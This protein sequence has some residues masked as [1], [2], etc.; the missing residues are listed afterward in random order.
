MPVITEQ[1]LNDAS[2][3]AVSFQLF[4]SGDENTD[5]HTRLGR[6][7]PTLAKLAKFVRDQPIEALVGQSYA[8][9]AS[10]QAAIVAGQIAENAV[11]NVYSADDDLLYLL[12]KNVGG[13][14]TPLLDSQGQHKAYPSFAYISKQL[15]RLDSNV[16]NNLPNAGIFNVAGKNAFEVIS[17]I[18]Q[19]AF[20]LDMRGVA[21][22][23]SGEF[24]L[25]EIMMLP[26]PPES[27]Y[28][29]AIGDKAGR[30]V[31]GVGKKGW[32]EILYHRMEMVDGQDAIIITDK[33]NATSVGIAANGVGFAYGQTDKETDPILQFVERLHILIYG[34]SLSI[35]AQGVP[36]LGT[37]TQDALM[38]NT[39]VISRFSTP[40]SFVDLVER[41]QETIA[42]A[43]A[44]D[45]VK[46]S[47]GMLGRKLIL[48]SGGV[49]GERIQNLIKGTTPYN[50][51]V[52][53]AIWAHNQ[54]AT[55]G[56]QHSPDLVCWLQGE[57]NMADGM[58]K[59]VYKNYLATLRSDLETSLASIRGG[60][61]RPFTM[62]TYQ[63]SSHGYYNGTPENPP[64]LIALGQLELALTDPNIQMIGPTYYGPRA[65]VSG[66][67]HHN[68]HGYRWVGLFFQKAIRY[69]L[70]TGEKWKPVHP[71]GARKINDTTV[72]I[73]FH[74]PVPPLVFDTS[75]ITQ[76]EDGQNGIEVHDSTG[77]LTVLSTTIVGGTQVKVVTQQ[78]IGSGAFIATA[79]TPENRGP[80]DTENNRYPEWFFGP[81]TG[82][83]TTLHDSDP[84]T[85]DLGNFDN[86]PYPL[87]N[88]C[89]ISKVEVTS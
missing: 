57:A 70:R 53:Q 88:Y 39:G 23:Q 33:E 75:Y 2:L 12:Y 69:W 45:F 50:Q 30:V 36:L 56:Y 16:I 86:K 40:T 38:Y 63:T 89:V 28:C 1:Q 68:S 8:D 82:V 37:P 34:Q 49:S 31:F 21:N 72:I 79:W 60:A 35:G 59:D 13:T 47:G 9:L 44:H 10:A 76:L 43:L 64:E 5:V 84:E 62:F 18:G 66:N 80:L 11:F 55:D 73:D 41:T 14:A 48:N 77:R 29:F 32:V 3:D 81:V 78:T 74:V 51:L 83:R 27:E 54:F 15:G 4:I 71:T 19:V 22:V 61:T 87:H 7:Y 85:T 58:N 24:N 42:S 25:G 20:S 52:N 46:K 6:V 26:C 17:A 65:V 67:V